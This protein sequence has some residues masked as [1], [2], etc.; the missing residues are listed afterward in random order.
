M[1]AHAVVVQEW[2]TVLLPVGH[3]HWVCWSG[4]GPWS[5]I[6]RCREVPRTGLSCQHASLQSL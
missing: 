1:H 3:C 6:P 2:P 5:T 4:S